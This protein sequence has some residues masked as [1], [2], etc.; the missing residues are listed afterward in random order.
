MPVLSSVK[1]TLVS[2]FQEFFILIFIPNVVHSVTVLFSVFSNPEK[3]LCLSYPLIVLSYI[4][5]V[6]DFHFMFDLEDHN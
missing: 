6:I 5:S 3:N 2:C 4:I 1:K